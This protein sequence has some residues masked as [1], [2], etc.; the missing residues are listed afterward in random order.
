MHGFG[1]IRKNLIPKAVIIDAAAR[2]LV[3][4]ADRCIAQRTARSDLR[5]LRGV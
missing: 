4:L 2:I 3:R 1:L 5:M